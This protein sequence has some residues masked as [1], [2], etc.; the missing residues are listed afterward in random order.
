MQ[1]VT[2]DYEKYIGCTA[3]DDGK[4]YIIHFVREDPVDGD[5]KITIVGRNTSGF[6]L[7][8]ALMLKQL[9]VL[10]LVL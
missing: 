7:Q 8:F 6:T 10:N 3:N 9:L 1:D 5:V 2:I 4:T